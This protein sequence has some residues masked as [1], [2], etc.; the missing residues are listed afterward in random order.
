[1]ATAP[2]RRQVCRFVGT[3]I[4]AFRVK[5]R[6]CWDPATFGF[7]ARLPRCN[8]VLVSRHCQAQLCSLER[9]IGVEPVDAC[10][11]RPLIHPLH[12]PCHLCWPRCSNSRHAFSLSALHFGSSI[13]A[14]TEAPSAS[15]EMQHELVVASFLCFVWA[16]EKVFARFEVATCDGGRAN[17]C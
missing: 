10:D 6:W 7:F 9:V 4:E 8:L 5:A 1:V 13:M 2:A 11:V 17:R 3:V 15:F 12:N 16:M 14:C